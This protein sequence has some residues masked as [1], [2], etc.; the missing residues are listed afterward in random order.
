MIHMEI[1]N[2]FP[3]DLAGQILGLK[4]SQVA[5]IKAG[6]RELT[7]L[8]VLLLRQSCD[9]RLLHFFNWTPD[10]YLFWR[11]VEELQSR[12]KFSDDKMA[13][14]F[15]VSIRI[16]RHSRSI[17][18]S[19][20]WVCC[21][22]FGMRFKL[23]PAL[24]FTTDI[25]IK[26]LADNIASPFRSNAYIPSRF[27]GGGSK[28]R[29]LANLV[30]YVHNKWGDETAEALKSALQITQESLNF[31]KSVSIRAFSEFHS[32]LRIF[33]ATDD[34]YESM[35][36]YNRQNSKNRR[37]LSQKTPAHCKSFNQII[38]HFIENL[39]TTQEINRKFTIEKNTKNEIWIRTEPTQVFLQAY[40]PDPPFAE[41]EIALYIKGHIKV[42]PAY[43]CLPEFTEVKLEFDSTTGV[44]LYKCSVPV[45]NR[46]K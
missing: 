3:L 46:E 26:C 35:G 34:D 10:E 24:W 31:E 42:I 1:L 41:Y 22:Y 6:T 9:D 11:N 12:L 30:T 23:H 21:E 7:A 8:E 13:Q 37:L 32:K 5:N 25:D 28:M 27:E 39:I 4:K 43:F 36:Q 15:S 17:V 20:P 16:F 33:G 14:A 40:L 18:K 44:A 19:L 2:Q 38:V 45:D 29:L